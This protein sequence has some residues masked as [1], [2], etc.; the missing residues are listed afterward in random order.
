MYLS[1]ASE[2]ARDN[3]AGLR[4]LYLRTV[5][6]AAAF[7]APILLLVLLPARW[8]FPFVFGEEWAETGTFM[9]ALAVMF[10]LSFLAKTVGPETLTVVRRQ[11]LHLVI[12]LF[13]AALVIIAFS[14]AIAA[15]TEPVVTIFM[16]G[17]AM[18]IGHL[19]FLWT[20]YVQASKFARNA[21]A[22]G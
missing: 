11:G 4:R 9:Q 6:L 5:G 18:S 3:P 19:A 15:D 17:L 1:N 10:F 22:V 2:E 16:Y 7:A 14:I 20:G 8:T 12:E 21:A 13:K